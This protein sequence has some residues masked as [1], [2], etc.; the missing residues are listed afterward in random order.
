[1][2]RSFLAAVLISAVLLVG[3][4]GAPLVPV[5]LGAAVAWGWAWWRRA[6]APHWAA[7]RLGG[8]IA[9]LPCARSGAA[10]RSRRAVPSRLR[11][12]IS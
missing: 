1:V 5:A 6:R 3:Y 11:R 8:E 9:T 10:W 4:C 12:C 2:T 7:R